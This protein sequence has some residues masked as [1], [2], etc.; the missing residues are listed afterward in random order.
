MTFLR[1]IFSP[2]S[3]CIKRAPHMET[4]DGSTMGT[5]YGVKFVTDGHHDLPTLR[6]QIQAAVDSVDSQMSTWKPQSDLSQFNDSAPDSWFPVSADLAF[7]VT[8]GL[9]IS[10]MTDGAFDMSVGS[11]VNDWGFGP[12]GC[13]N[14]VPKPNENAPP[15]SF[16]DIKAQLSPPALFKSKPAYLDLSGIAKG[17][18]VD[19]V[20]EALN[21]HGISNYIIE[22]DGEVRA[23]GS[24]PDGTKWVVGLQ[25]PDT[26]EHGVLRVM[27]L[28]TVALATSGDY[29]RFFEKDGI[30]YSHTIDPRTRRPTTSPVA[31]VTVADTSCARADAL[32]TA[33]LVMGPE[34]GPVFASL[35]HISALFLVREG[36]TLVARRT[37]R[38]DELWQD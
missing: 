19:A 8:R 36:D 22:I 33:L 29:R 2:K 34:E 30:R 16:K 5:R 4:L 18:G 23:S 6:R 37:H 12:G 7:V 26:S 15:A 38:F 24:K 3:E 17:F 35:N 27:A 11:I 14:A 31:S 10:S 21:R 20:A 32:A 25:R 9:D 28:G 1:A 13:G